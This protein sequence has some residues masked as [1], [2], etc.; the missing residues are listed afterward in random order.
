[1]KRVPTSILIDDQELRTVL[2][3]PTA[4]Y[5]AIVSWRH[6]VPKQAV[7]PGD[8][9]LILTNM[10]AAGRAV[11][12]TVVHSRGEAFLSLL[13]LDDIAAFH[14]RLESL[15]GEMGAALMSDFRASL[16]GR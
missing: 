1:M 13:S 6:Y 12:C 11:L 15:P 10:V 9:E 3:N 4:L 7:I 2:A 14:E 5:S 16:A 8:C